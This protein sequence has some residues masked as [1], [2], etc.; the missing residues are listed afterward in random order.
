MKKQTHGRRLLVAFL[1]LIAG[2]A[3]FT[4]QAEAG[5]KKK[6]AKPANVSLTVVTTNQQQLLNQKKLSV[7]V[8]STGKA[9]PKLTVVSGGKSNY[10]RAMTV[11][12]KKKGTKTVKLALTSSGRTALGKCGAK[13]VTVNASYK[14]GKKKARAKRKKTLA[15]WAGNPN[16]IEYVQVDLGDNPETCDFLDATACLHPWPN[17][18][19]LKDDPS[20]VT[21][22]RLNLDP[23][24]TPANKNGVRIDVTDINRGDGFSPGNLIVVK[25]P[26]LETPAA[27]E[28]ND[29]VTLG[30]LHAYD[31]PSQ[32]VLLIDAETGE[33]QPIWAELDANPTSTD[34]GEDGPG[35]INTNPTNTGPVNV[36]IRP[37]KN[38]EWGHRY[39]VAFR[40]I[41]DANDNP[42]AAPLGFRVYRDNLPTRQDV[43]ENR[44]DHMNSVINDLVNKAGVERSSLYMA[45]DFTVASQ[46]SVTGRALQARDD[47]FARLGDNN[48]ANRVIEGD[49]PEVVVTYSCDRYENPN[50]NAPVSDECRNGPN[51]PSGVDKR[52]SVPGSDLIRVVDGYINDVPCYLN[53]NG[54]PSGATFNFKPDHT[55]DFNENFT[56]DVPF[57]CFIPTA[58]QPGG[59]NTAVTPGQAGIYGHGLLGDLNQITSAGPVNVANQGGSVWCGANWDGFSTGDLLAVFQSLGDMSNFPKMADR[60]IQGFVNFMMIQRAMI[61]EDGF[62]ANPAFQLDPDGAGGEDPVSAID[63][64]GSPNT[65]GIYMGISQGGI[66]G[67]AL[68]ALTPDSDYGV[69]GVPGMN[70]STL[71]R[72]S[73]DSDQ[74]FKTPGVGLYSNYPDEHERPLLLSLVQLL[75]DRGEANGYANNM[76]LDPLPDTP[77]HRV[78]L[79]VAYGDHQ[80]TNY[81]AEVE[82]RTIGAGVYSPALNEGRHWDVD[83]FLGM[84]KIT[85]FPNV[86]DS[87]LVYYD[88]GPVDFVGDR[89]AG[90]G[91]PPIEEL[92]PRS[93][94]GYGRDPH[95]DPRRSPDGIDQATTF[96]QNATIRSCEII[97]P[98]PA[99]DAHCYANDYEGPTP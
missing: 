79:R 89:G 54:C 42:V 22:K 64:S 41:R 8:K 21:G 76:T 81:S 20:S 43:V 58:V 37:A 91:K 36:I 17:D 85:S 77:E 86:G 44:R 56:M 14:K 74:Y 25:I 88:S 28:N 46:E 31:D 40:D 4:T 98:I 18:Y 62:A 67:G 72:R 73:V 70:Y 24:S 35:G 97:T 30:D 83:P 48:L 32:R 12:F 34:P 50:P 82:A 19:F 75:W 87:I 63:I 38:L 49:S 51:A 60:M 59:E 3:A 1:A 61:H 52:P 69:L 66:M 39:I 9:S 7:K 92:P 95:E 93:E 29:F 47:A 65:R 27:F 96:L 10:F 13:T 53:Q 26:G 6:K 33:R 84:E 23:S 94:W 2:L 15:K 78:M 5:K 80:V 99:G 90:I 55:I 45:W 68:M 11:K 16:C 71:L 57:R